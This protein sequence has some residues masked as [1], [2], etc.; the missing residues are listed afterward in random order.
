MATTPS[1]HTT[2][3]P[4]KVSDDGPAPAPVAPAAYPGGMASDPAA[5][6]A[7]EIVVNIKGAIE[8]MRLELPPDLVGSVAAAIRGLVNSEVAKATGG[9]APAHPPHPPANDKKV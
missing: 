9:V 4:P 3:P 1:T 6:T 5:A 7:N 2:T 8:K